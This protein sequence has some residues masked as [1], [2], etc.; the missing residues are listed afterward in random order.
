[1]YAIVK[2][3]GGKQYRVEPGKTIDV[4]KLPHEAGTALDL[5]EVL[6]VVTDGGEVRIGQPTVS[7][8][9]VKAT[10]VEDY[11]GDKVLIWKY[12]PG[13]R[14]RRRRGHRQTYTRLRIESVTV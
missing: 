9:V 3:G 12:R 13:L 11:R 5:G 8:A 6:L 2:I 1:M 10:V 14:Y 4:E 7:G